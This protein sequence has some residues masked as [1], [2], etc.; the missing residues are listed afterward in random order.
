MINLNR[1]RQM[2]YIFGKIVLIYSILFSGLNAEIR[3]QAFEGKIHSV[4]ASGSDTSYVNYYI[5]GNSVRVDELDSRKKMTKFT[6][7]NLSDN[8]IRVFSPDKKLFKLLK[9]SPYVPVENKGFEINKTQNYKD[10]EGYRCYQWIVKNKETNTYVAYWV[11]QDSFF[12][13][14]DFLKLMNKS[15]KSSSYY[16]LI[17]DSKGFYPFEIEERTLLREFRMKMAVEEVKKEKIDD[18]LFLIPN[19]YTSFDRP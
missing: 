17:P 8:S 1:Q 2:Y 19:D 7:F 12:F 14:N 15:E 10:I 6:I 16:L 13:F 18:K 4:K 11:A 3:A 5:K 9:P